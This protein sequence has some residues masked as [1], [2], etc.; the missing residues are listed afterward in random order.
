MEYLTQ[1]GG[2]PRIKCA[3]LGF[4]MAGLKH[5]SHSTGHLSQVIVLPFGK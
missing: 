3:A 1:F 4:H 2:L 5:R